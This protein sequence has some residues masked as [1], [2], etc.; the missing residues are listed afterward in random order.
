MPL[1]YVSHNT[2]IENKIRHSARENSGSHGG[3]PGDDNLLGYSVV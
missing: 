3:K 2:R 1:T